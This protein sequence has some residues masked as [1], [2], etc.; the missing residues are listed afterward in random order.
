MTQ[1]AFH[2]V[3]T[4]AL[5]LY[6]DGRTL[7]LAV[8]PLAAT[9]LVEAE[10]L[11]GDTITPVARGRATQAV[12][13]WAIGELRP[14]GAA[15]EGQHPTDEPQV[16]TPDW[17]FYKI[18]Q[19]FY[20]DHWTM[21]RIAEELGFAP[22][23]IFNLRAKALAA[24]A[25]LLQSALATPALLATRQQATIAHR[26]QQLQPAA[27]TIV[28]IAAFW[29]VPIPL[30]MLRELIPVDTVA[31]LQDRIALV[32][33][34]AL[35]VYDRDAGTLY[36]PPVIRDYLLGQLRPDERACWHQRAAQY[37]ETQGNYLEAARHWY[38]AGAGETAA[39]L[40]IT[41][42]AAISKRMKGAEAAEFLASFQPVDVA[43]PTWARLKL[44]E[45][46]LAEAHANLAKA[47]LAYETA[48]HADLVAIKAEAHYRLAKILEYRNVDEALVHYERGISL[49]EQTSADPPLLVRMYIHRSWI[50]IQH[51]QDLR[52]AEA[53][54]QRAKDLIDP[55]NREDYADLYNASG[56]LFHRE[57]KWVYAI[58]DRLQAWLA[59]KES[60]D[61]A[62]I[63]KIGYNLGGD[64]A[65][66]RR[67][68][69]ALTYLNQ[70][71]TLALENGMLDMAALCQE[72]I[73]ICYFYQADY[74]AAIHSY[75][76][77]YALFAQVQNQTA[78]TNACFNL[79]EV[80]ALEGHRAQ[81][82]RYYNEGLTLA[83]T[84]IQ[85]AADAA[86]LL[87]VQR[88]AEL[89]QQYPHLLADPGRVNARQQR[90]LAYVQQHGA[91]SNREYR[92]L[93]GVQ[94]KTA[95]AELKALAAQ[96]L[97]AKWG[98][99]AATVYRLPLSTRPATTAALPPDFNLRQRQA[100]AYVQ[101][102]GQISNRIYRE[103]TQVG[104]KAAATDLQELVAKGILIQSGKGP[105]TV[106]RLAD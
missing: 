105:A 54:L 1:L 39:R 50:F 23:S 32:V 59:A 103:L 2:A 101:V 63:V 3:V 98:Q 58:E 13:R 15:P 93:N 25:D 31:D 7:E 77:A 57:G 53:S 12:L 28:R 44:L 61:L 38:L 29:G 104:N 33:Q 86:S 85:G 10:F 94:N 42:A 60:N 102:H 91:I 51:R 14:Q 8:T 48:L 21:E 66:Y 34:C 41:H 65:E 37:D 16:L 22:T 100:V 71:R 30:R 40:L 24:L 6:R 5:K 47:I 84:L 36:T 67:F 55:T 4:Q 18:L 99:G 89:K 87:I 70:S 11:A 92:T 43:P 88:F 95:A 46:Q 45:G 20:I 78:L 97:L 72:V 27:Q 62:R 49:L 17:R 79:A 82:R 106:Y 74:A 69:Q 52:R 96:Q 64:Y 73:G 19:H 26:Y 35:A 83:A 56:E 80:H 81:T 76:A 90:A 9:A 75:E 68:P